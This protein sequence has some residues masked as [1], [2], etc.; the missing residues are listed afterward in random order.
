M[1]KKINW[2]SVVG[3]IFLTTSIIFKTLTYELSKWDMLLLFVAIC[4]ILTIEE[5]NVK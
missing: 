2:A 4:L 5:K 3:L 1:K